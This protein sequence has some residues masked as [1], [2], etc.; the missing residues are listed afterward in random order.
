MVDMSFVVK[1]MAR[2]DYQ[3]GGVGAG[4]QLG[5]QPPPVPPPQ[6]AVAAAAA[7]LPPTDDPHRWPAQYQHLWRQHVY[8]NMNGT[9]PLYHLYIQRTLTSKFAHERTKLNSSILWLSVCPE[10]VVF[11]WQ[12]HRRRKWS[13]ARTRL[14]HTPAPVLSI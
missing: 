6:V 7:P 14:V 8:N 3:L 5:Y 13:T 1:E 10:T 12:D 4:P 2:M 11:E 9:I